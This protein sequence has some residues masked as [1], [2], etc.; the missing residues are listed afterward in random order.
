MVYKKKCVFPKM[1]RKT[2]GRKK[3]KPEI[4]K[5]RIEDKKRRLKEWKDWG[6]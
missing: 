2:I 5:A 3:E 1:G 6:G 4:I